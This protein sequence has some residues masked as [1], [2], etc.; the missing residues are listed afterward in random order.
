MF[1]F[2]NRI[3]KLKAIRERLVNLEVDIDG[4]RRKIDNLDLDLQLSKKKKRIEKQ[5]NEEETPKNDPY[6]GVLGY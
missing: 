1:N 4:L 6:K 2:F 5:D 3:D